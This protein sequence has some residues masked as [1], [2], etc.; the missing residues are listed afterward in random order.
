M[1]YVNGDGRNRPIEVLTEEGI[2]FPMSH[3]GE[4]PSEIW[5]A[6]DFADIGSTY[7]V[8]DVLRHWLGGLTYDEEIDRRLRSLRRGF[9]RQRFPTSIGEAK[10]IVLS[11]PDDA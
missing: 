1:E 6:R 11:Q 3:E 9:D 4:I 5:V 7:R 8:E 10:Y 2:R